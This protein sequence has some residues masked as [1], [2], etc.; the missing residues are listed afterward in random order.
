MFR[1][2]NPNWINKEIL[3]VNSV[4]KYS[5]EFL[6]QLK[7][8]LRKVVSDKPQVTVC[9]A[10]WNEEVNI[11][12]CLD[13]LSRSKSQTPFDILVVNN[14]STDRTQEML[15]QLEVQNV[16]QAIQGC[17]ISRELGQQKAKGEYV[18]LADA[19]CLYPPLWVD[20]M[21]KY[22]KKPGVVV[23]YGKH[24]FLGDEIVPRWK[25]SFYELGK[26]VI[27]EIRHV[28]RPYL[29]AYGMSMG[30]LKKFGLQEGFVTRNIRGED[31]RMCLDL[32]KHG[33]VMMVRDGRSRVW[34]K[35]RNF[36]KD[37]GLF[38][39]IQKRMLREAVRLSEYFKKPVPHDTKTSENNELTTEE[40]KSALKSKLG[41]K[42]S[43]SSK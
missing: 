40:Y 29:N 33:K 3:N 43:K 31:G 25:F 2:N 30:Y 22:L 18:L 42:K 36:E 8:R 20:V 41:L 38:N 19:D 13:S 28:K 37:G 23:V 9:I 10:A 12:R 27:T 14:N 32:M 35:E 5:E 4:D 7:E 15:D 39:S 34:T 6:L 26:S 11:V 21:M 1:I 24:S 17:G 16:F